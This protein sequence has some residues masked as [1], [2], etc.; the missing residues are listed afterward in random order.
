MF[1][2]IQPI[3][4][5]TYVC[6]ELFAKRAQKHCLSNRICAGEAYLHY[7]VMLVGDQDKRWAPRVIFDYC[8]RI[9]E[10]G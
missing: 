5:T 2:N 1:A 6:D 8:R 10:A 4:F 3:P 7:F 9:L